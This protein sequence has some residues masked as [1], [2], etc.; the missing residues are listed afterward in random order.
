MFQ[1]LRHSVTCNQVKSCTKHGRPVL[2]QRE[3]T[4]ALNGTKNVVPRDCRATQ[5]L[6][7]GNETMHYETK[8]SSTAL[9]ELEPRISGKLNEWLRNKD[10][11]ARPHGLKA[12]SYYHGIKV[13]FPR[14]LCTMCSI[15]VCLFVCLTSRSVR[16]HTWLL[17]GPGSNKMF[18][19]G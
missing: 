1:K 13:Y 10:D 11:T 15:F 12:G 16:R 17:M 9:V 14:I 8:D 6:M 7:N 18:K 3:L 19:P 5:D 4:V 2:S